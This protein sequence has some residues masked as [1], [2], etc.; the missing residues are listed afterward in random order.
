[1]HWSLRKIFKLLHLILQKC[2]FYGTEWMCDVMCHH[3]H[4]LIPVIFEIA[5]KCRSMWHSFPSIMFCV[6]IFT[7]KC[8]CLSLDRLLSFRCD[9]FSEVLNLWNE[10]ISDVTDAIPPHP[11]CAVLTLQI[12][13]PYL[14]GPRTGYMQ[15]PEHH[16]AIVRPNADRKVWNIGF[17]LFRSTF[18]YGM[19]WLK[20]VDKILPNRTIFRLLKSVFNVWRKG[21]LRIVNSFYRIS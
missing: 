4:W 9:Y 2:F 6:L 11:S 15:M 16:Y 18:V 17:Q 3:N 14:H 1:M 5:N 13:V 10:Y 12:E 20:M 21:Y 7:Y 8:I 19:L